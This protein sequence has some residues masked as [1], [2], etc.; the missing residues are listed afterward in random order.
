MTTIAPRWLFGEMTCSTPDKTCEFDIIHNLNP[1]PAVDD[2]F[3]VVV[4]VVVVALP[5]RSASHLLLLY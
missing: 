4:V 1:L 3:D 5:Q 2:S